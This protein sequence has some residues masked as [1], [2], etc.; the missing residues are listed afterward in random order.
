MRNFLWRTREAVWFMLRDMTRDG[1]RTAITTLTLFVFLCCYFCLAA[2]ARAANDYG[3]PAG[4]K[5]TLLVISK[6]VL[7][8]ADSV[9]TEADMTPIKTL[10]PDKVKAVSPLIYKLVK[11][12]DLLIQILGARQEEFISVF[13]LELREGNWPSSPEEV[14][15]SEDAAALAKWKIGES[16]FIYGKPFLISGIVSAPGT[17]ASSVWMP[18]ETAHD[19]FDTGP[20]YQFAWVALAEKADGGKIRTLLQST[21]DLGERF[22]VFFVDAL[23]QQYAEALAGIRD[24]S[25]VLV[26]FALAMVMFGTY[27]SVYLTLSERSREIAILRAIG[28]SSHSLRG[29]LILRL[30]IQAVTAFAAAWIFSALLLNRFN[31]VS[32]LTINSIDMPVFVDWQILSLGLLL[33]AVFCI[34]GVVI[35]TIR[36]NFSTV[37]ESIQR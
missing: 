37:H 30:L 35:P 10:G 21:P 36:M 2:L 7:N 20:V 4:N 11:I 15:I 27:G 33:S 6:S 25:V 24:F 12:D 19:L 28:F 34:A 17:K 32:P 9:I 31:T 23:Y 29:L 18:M 22:D 1:W 26:F 3:A 8:P 14:V 16:I 5:S 13:N